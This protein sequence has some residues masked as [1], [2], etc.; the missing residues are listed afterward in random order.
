MSDRD[1]Y[2]GYY[3][4]SYIVHRVSATFINVDI[5]FVF[6]PLRRDTDTPIASKQW[7][8]VNGYKYLQCIVDKWTEYT[9]VFNVGHRISK[10][11]VNQSQLAMAANRSHFL[12]PCSV[13]GPPRC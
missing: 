11:S 9:E 2:C 13:S 5:M 12:K 3:K 8:K 1:I 4:N 7:R 10:Y 6:G